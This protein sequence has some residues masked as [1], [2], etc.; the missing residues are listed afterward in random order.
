MIAKKHHIVSLSLLFVACLFLYVPSLRSFEMK[1][2]VVTLFFTEA[3]LFVARAWRA[4]Q[5]TLSIRALA[6]D[7]PS[8]R[9]LE[10]ASTVVGLVAVLQI[11]GAFD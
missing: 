5:L 2:I 11:M 8:T 9:V 7:P 6:K 1:I 10:F 4:G 3:A